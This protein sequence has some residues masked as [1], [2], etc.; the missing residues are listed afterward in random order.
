MTII[1]G[2]RVLGLTVKPNPI[3]WLL[4]TML[5]PYTRCLAVMSFL[6]VLGMTVISDPIL[7]GLA[8]MS[9]LIAWDLAM[10]PHPSTW[11]LADMPF[12]SA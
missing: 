11:G 4:A 2:S 12:S 6:G 3:A 7:L 5:D 9:N 10:M 1:S 8:A